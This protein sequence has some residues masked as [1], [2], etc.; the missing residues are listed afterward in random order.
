[1]KLLPIGLAIA[2]VSPVYAAE[3]PAK[4]AYLPDLSLRQAWIAP[5]RAGG[6]ADR[7][8]INRTQA[9]A[10]YEIFK[11]TSAGVS[12]QYTTISGR[13]QSGLPASLSLLEFPL[14]S[15]IPVPLSSEKTFVRL[16]ATPAFAADRLRV[17][18]KDFLFPYDAQYIYRVSSELDIG[19]GVVFGQ[20][21]SRDYFPIAGFVFHP[22][23]MTVSL[24]DEF[25]VAYQ[26]DPLDRVFAEYGGFLG[27]DE[28]RTR[29]TP[30]LKNDVLEFREEF[31][32][33]GAQRTKG[34]WTLSARI[35]QAFNRR[36]RM[37]ES[38]LEVKIKPGVYLVGG[39][40]RE[41]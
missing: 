35:G 12:E 4:K 18:G 37:R 14:E 24:T 16:G 28:Y 6:G 41:F 2:L 11:G 38:P 7:I 22:G 3:D 9:E 39:L 15:Y 20:G 17:S 31:A 8:G 40:D 25:A 36:L 34:L 19:V 1:M 10:S 21:F 27:A 29:N 26:V 5:S 13:G 33:V 23:M 30:F 32:G